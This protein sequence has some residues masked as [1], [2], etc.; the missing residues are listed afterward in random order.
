MTQ[1][2]ASHHHRSALKQT[3]KAFKGRS[4]GSAAHR[5]GKA[6]TKAKKPVAAIPSLSKTDRKNQAKMKQLTKREE[7]QE[8]KDLFKHP[9]GPSRMIFCIPLTKSAN[10]SVPFKLFTDASPF[11]Y[12]GSHKQR[13]FFES[14]S[15][16]KD[17][18]SVLLK[19]AAADTVVFVVSAMD[20]DGID[21]FG[22]ACFSAVRSQGISSAVAFIQ[23]LQM[24]PREDKRKSLKAEWTELFKME[25]ATIHPRVFSE[26][27]Q[28][29]FERTLCTMHLNGV[30][31]REIRPYMHVQATSQ[32]AEDCVKVSG[33]ARGNHSFHANSYVH[34]TGLGDFPVTQVDITDVRGEKQS[35]LRTEP[36]E[37]SEE[38]EMGSKEDAD[39]EDYKEEDMVDDSEQEKTDTVPK[40]TSDYQSSWYSGDEGDEQEAEGISSKKVSFAAQSEA[41]P[42]MMI[43]DELDN[44]QL[45]EHRLRAQESKKKFPDEFELDD[46]ILAKERLSKYRGVKS[47]RT[48]EWD[49]EDALPE[50][51]SKVFTFQNYRY[52]RKRALNPQVP[53]PTVGTFVEL[54]VKIHQSLVGNVLLN[55]PM[56]VVGLLKHEEKTTVMHFTIKRTLAAL[57][58][59]L[60]SKDE[61][62]VVS[63]FRRYAVQPIFSMY[64]PAFKLHK[65]LRYLP[66]DGVHVA[67]FYMPLTYDPCP[68][69]YFNPSNLALVATGSVLE[70][71]PNRVILKRITLTG[72]PFK[73]HKRVAVVRFMFFNPTDIAWFKPVELETRDYRRGL[74]KES[75][76]THGYMKC[77]FDK[78]ISHQDVV[79]MHLY[80]RIFP[81]FTTR[82]I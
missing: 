7:V 32:V 49:L 66:E 19:A 50:E 12:S 26:H 48:A 37:Q 11:Y 72:I 40:G 20:E 28:R 38:V 73:I 71:N 53:V 55:P 15:M 10:P 45:E 70:C 61:L 62:L 33:F 42:S 69:L 43:E 34:L 77:T 58:S 21:E 36:T 59:P 29:E 76:G 78:Q 6:A 64:N 30:S 44:Q 68:V 81:K 74:I 31:W 14:V 82:A 4:S 67:S 18:G 52:S 9:Q 56:V 22:A 3:N 47:L 8:V 23:D 39:M 27:E 54:Y 41:T 24:I 1:Q 35:F 16:N 75:L 80:K 2:A 13:L 60:K 17:I 57:D 65:M 63:G 79:L 46:D 25:L 5:K 51:Y